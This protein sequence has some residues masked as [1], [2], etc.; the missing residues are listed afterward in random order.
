MQSGILSVPLIKILR[1]HQNVK[2]DKLGFGINF[3][4]ISTYRKRVC[5]DR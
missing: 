1:I 2:L 4:K 3:Q 5:G